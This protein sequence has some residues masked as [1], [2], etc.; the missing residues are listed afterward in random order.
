MPG[1]VDDATAKAIVE[2]YK[3]GDK[4][5]TIEQA[6][7]ISRAT[8][9][10][11]LDASGVTASRRPDRYVGDAKTIASLYEVVERQQARIRELESRLG[12]EDDDDA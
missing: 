10:R 11:V 6:F 4:L 3:R 8:L 7:S 1:P 12:I 2:A 5:L 9:Y